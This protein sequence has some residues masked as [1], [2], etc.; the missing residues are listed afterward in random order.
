[1]ADI[2]RGTEDYNRPAV[3]RETFNDRLGVPFTTGSGSTVSGLTTLEFGLRA[4]IAIQQNSAPGVE[5]ETTLKSIKLTIENV[6]RVSGGTELEFTVLLPSDSV[7]AASPFFGDVNA[8]IA[9]EILD[10]GTEMDELDSNGWTVSF[11]GTAEEG[12]LR[13]IAPGDALDTAGAPLNAA[14]SSSVKVMPEGQWFVTVELISWDGTDNYYWGGGTFDVDRQ[15]KYFVPELRDLA[16]DGVL[17][18]VMVVA[19]AADTSDG[20]DWAATYN[21][22]SP[23]GAVEMDGEDVDNGVIGG[24]NFTG[25]TALSRAQS[26]VI[27]P[28][29]LQVDLVKVK[30][31]I[32]QV[33]ATVTSVPTYVGTNGETVMVDIPGGAKSIC[34]W[35]DEAA[36]W[37]CVTLT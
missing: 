13:V 34:V 29:N 20:L 24:P 4:G 14:I 19:R 31:L 33:H 1:M 9:Q 25:D 27:N 17:Q 36:A 6:N 37:A 12:N 23:E 2:N 22:L 32:G 16:C 5:V 15:L 21:G 3:V 35:S 11:R 8:W 28:Y 26:T 7:V 18:E 10:G 30:P